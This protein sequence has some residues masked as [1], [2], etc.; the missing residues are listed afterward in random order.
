MTSRERTHPQRGDKLHLAV[1]QRSVGLAS[2][3]EAAVA[4]RGE[5]I[6]RAC[7]QR[8]PLHAELG[9]TPRGFTPGIDSGTAQF[10]SR[11]QAF[12]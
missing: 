3:K 12:E 1:S 4:E 6:H 5:F 7:R 9:D 11:D 2:P 10:A 8:R